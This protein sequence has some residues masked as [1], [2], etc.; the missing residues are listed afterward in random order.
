MARRRKFHPLNLS[1]LDIMACGFGAVTLLFLILKHGAAELPTDPILKA[2][3]DL[4]N[5][6]ILQG[7]QDKVKVRNSLKAM[8]QRLVEAQ[9]KARQVVDEITKK[10]PRESQVVDPVAELA[11]LRKQVEELEK[12]AAEMRENAQGQNLRTIA[13]EGNRQYLTGLKL[14]GQ[15]VLILLDSSASMLAEDLVNVIRRRNMDDN[16]KRSADKWQRATRTAE[17]LLAQ[18]PPHSRFQLYTFNTQAVSTL[19]A[20]TG[21]WQDAADSAAVAAAVKGMRATVPNGGTSLANAFTAIDRMSPKPDNVFLIT[22]GLPTQ[23]TTAPKGKTVSARERARYFEDAVNILPR[24]PVNVILFPMEG[25]PAAAGLFWQLG[26]VT[27]G[28]F[29]SPATDWP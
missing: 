18:V 26:L 24:V 1:F 21:G 17:W 20:G 19:G 11:E 6:E 10:Q 22:D 7:E 25:D 15:R 23:G 9:G 27:R 29:L 5:E 13:G 8:Q 12:K 14:G 3:V 28:S 16:A 2:E 4:L